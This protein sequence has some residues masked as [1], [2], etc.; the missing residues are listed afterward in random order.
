MLPC[1]PLFCARDIERVCEAELV[2]RIVVTGEVDEDS[3]PY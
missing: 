1:D 3:C 2:V